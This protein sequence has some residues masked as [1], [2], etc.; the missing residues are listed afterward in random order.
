MQLA[1][2]L[3]VMQLHHYVQTYTVI[4]MLGHVAVWVA[5]HDTIDRCQWE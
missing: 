2:L 1:A 3:H 5:V 4:A